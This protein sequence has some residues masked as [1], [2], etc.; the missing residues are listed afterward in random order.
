MTLKHVLVL[1][2]TINLLSTCQG[3]LLGAATGLAVC[4]SGCH[5]GYFTCLVAGGGGA[6]I[7]PIYYKNVYS[8][9]LSI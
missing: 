1:I 3:G 9:S 2:L 8:T 7:K 5:A 6:G 4:T